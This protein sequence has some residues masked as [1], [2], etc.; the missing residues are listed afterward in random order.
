MKIL[1]LSLFALFF[2]VVTG[3]LWKSR[4]P[5][6][7]GSNS[8]P[9]PGAPTSSDIQSGLEM[10]LPALGELSSINAEINGTNQPSTGSYANHRAMLDGD[11]GLD[12][13]V[14]RGVVDSDRTIQRTKLLI[15][16][17]EN[18][19]MAFNGE[20][21]FELNDLLNHLISD[22]SGIVAILEYQTTYPLGPKHSQKIAKLTHLEDEYSENILKL[23][24]ARDAASLWFLQY[25]QSVQGVS[26]KV[27]EEAS[28]KTRLAIERMR[29]Q[30]AGEDD[31][32]EGP[33]IN[34]DCILVPS[35]GQNNSVVLNSPDGN[36]FACSVGNAASPEQY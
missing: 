8:Q 33:G 6:S 24:L 31:K 5:E 23:S 32:D 1:A 9:G 26:T 25:L 19:P 28:S 14:H 13:F 35:Q 10:I 7:Q 27:D 30:Y 3:S 4:H 29:Q 12:D 11:W 21:G 16:H 18:Q 17:L 34:F 36:R 2:L 15:Q 22:Q 20:Q